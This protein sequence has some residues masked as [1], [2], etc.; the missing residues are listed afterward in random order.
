MMLSRVTAVFAKR[1]TFCEE[2]EEEEVVECVQ[3]V[4]GELA[5][6]RLVDG[7]EVRLNMACGQGDDEERFMADVASALLEAARSAC[8]V[9]GGASKGGCL[10][11]LAEIVAAE[12]D[13]CEAVAASLVANEAVHDLLRP[14]TA[15]TSWHAAESR[16]EVRELVDEAFAAIAAIALCTDEAIESFC[17]LSLSSHCVWICFRGR[18]RHVTLALIG[19]EEQPGDDEELQ[20]ARAFGDCLRG[21]ARPSASAL[22]SLVAEAFDHT[23]VRS[24]WLGCLSTTDEARAT[25]DLVERARDVH[26]SAT[27]SSESVALSV[28]AERV[29]WFADFGLDL[30]PRD[31]AT[32][33]LVNIQPEPWLSRRVRVAVDDEIIVG[34][35]RGASLRLGRSGICERHCSLARRDEDGLIRVRPGPRGSPLVSINGEQVTDDERAL[36]DGDVLALG[37]GAVFVVG[38]AAAADWR[39][40]G[41]FD[42][43]VEDLFASASSSAARLRLERRCRLSLARVAEANALADELGR[44]V[45]FDLKLILDDIVITARS[46]KYEVDDAWSEDKLAARLPRMRFMRKRFQ[47]DLDRDLQRL[48][49]AF[50]VDRDPFYDSPDHRLI[51]VAFLYLDALTYLLELREAVP[52]VDYKGNRAGELVVH[53]AP[54]LPNDNDDDDDDDDDSQQNIGFD[55]DEVDLAKH[56]GKIL[57]LQLRIVA[58]RGL[59][60]RTSASVFVRCTWFLNTTPLDTPRCHRDTTDPRFDHL[61]ALRQIITHDFLHY[62]KDSALEF[63]LYGQSRAQKEH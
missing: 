45:N 42:A 29:A 9:F 37:F 6:V 40:A 44:D 31:D 62:L 33:Y 22:T 7:R 10:S 50:P 58:A 30:R 34:G 46:D 55:T 52:I 32:S 24:V 25:L 23:R 60:P 41:L 51:G 27:E 63:Q 26:Y 28:R 39:D 57:A 18:G 35:R 3:P 36:E 59:P 1:A 5:T 8:F 54:S 16:D 61:F 49:L 11:R 17:P 47:T 38:D 21:V 53:L 13:D 20:S 56:V 43:Q 12:C 2:E 4:N 14:G 19:S 15:G 48:D